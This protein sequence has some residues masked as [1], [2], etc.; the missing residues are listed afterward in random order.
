MSATC[1][2]LHNLPHVDHS[3]TEV[4]NQFTFPRNRRFEQLYQWNTNPY[5]QSIQ[6]F[7]ILCAVIGGVLILLVFAAAY[8]WNVYRYHQ[9][10]HNPT[11]C[12]KYCRYVITI[13]LFACMI[14]SFVFIFELNDTIISMESTLDEMHQSFRVLLDDLQIMIEAI[15]MYVILISQF[16]KLNT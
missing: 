3:F 8:W 6:M 10:N 15:T 4:D 9:R 2:Q 5:Q 14:A 1:T 7:I 13:V 16:A 11:K 12:T